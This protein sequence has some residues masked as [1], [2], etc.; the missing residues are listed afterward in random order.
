MIRL[1]GKRG[2]ARQPQARRD[3]ESL[4]LGGGEHRQQETQIPA[5]SV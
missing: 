4:P 3:G 1:L 5:L 2:L